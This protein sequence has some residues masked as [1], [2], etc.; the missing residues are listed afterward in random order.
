MARSGEAVSTH[1]RLNGACKVSLDTREEIEMYGLVQQE[2]W[3]HRPEEIR[4]EVAAIRLEKALRADR[5]RGSSPGRDLRWEIARFAGLLGKRFR[6]S[7]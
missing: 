6:R 1:S 2:A 7:H 5:G 4:Q 3:R